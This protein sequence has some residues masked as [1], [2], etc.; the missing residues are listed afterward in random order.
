MMIQGHEKAGGVDP[1][2]A[3]LLHDKL[4]E[5]VEDPQPSGLRAPCVTGVL[6][7]Q[8]LAALEDEDDEGEKVVIDTTSHGVI[9][10]VDSKLVTELNRK[11][12]EQAATSNEKPSTSGGGF[13]GELSAALERKLG[14]QEPPASQAA[15]GAV[16]NELL[17]AVERKLGKQG[18]DEELEKVDISNMSGLRAPASTVKLSAEA[19][20]ALDDEDDEVEDRTKMAPVNHGNIDNINDKLVLELQRKLANADEETRDAVETT[21]PAG[22]RAPANTMK[23]TADVMNALDDEDGPPNRGI[24]VAALQQRFEAD[25]DDAVDT[26]PVRG[27]RAPQPTMKLS[28]DMLAEIDADDDVD[29]VPAAVKPRGSGQFDPSFASELTQK[30]AEKKGDESGLRAPEPTKLIS[31]DMLADL[32]DEEEATGSILNNAASALQGLPNRETEVARQ[33]FEEPAKS[34]KPKRGVSFGNA[35]SSQEDF[36]AKLAKKLNQ[37]LPNISEAPS[38]TTT[39]PDTLLPEDEEETDQRFKGGRIAPQCTQVLSADMLADIEDDDT[40]LGV[41]A[42]GRRAP[43]CTAVLAMGQLEQMDAESEQQQRQ[44]APSTA[45]SEFAAKVMQNMRDVPNG[46]AKPAS[47]SCRL[48]LAWLSDDEV[49]KE[50]DALRQEIV[51]L[52]AQ[53]E[54]HRKEACFARK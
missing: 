26:G 12:C 13:S 38:G 32:G 20:C 41:L 6:S 24:D 44:V 3:G 28:Q 40:A 23:L 54:M 35:G 33:Q 34:A 45:E 17:A 8:D 2:F 53:I 10:Q 29:F 1:N 11:L 15:M 25:A 43:E 19:L 37:D 30:L 21:A 46:S 5:K 52:R 49:R 39:L 36:A 50:N 7:M 27:T 18:S 9:D 51:S 31:S 4:A 14:S 48:R 47:S 42:S 16:N 22:F